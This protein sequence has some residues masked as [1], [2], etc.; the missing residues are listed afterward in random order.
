VLWLIDDN[1]AATKNLR[2]YASRSGA[3][4]SRI[5]FSPRSSYAEYRASLR[6]A[7]VFLDTY[8]YNCG[9]TTN[10]VVQAR[11][12]IVTVGGDT[13]VS[14][15]GTSILQAL[16][17]PQLIAADLNDYEN[18]VV[19]L[20][21]GKINLPQEAFNPQTVLKLTRQMVRSLESGLLQLYE[22]RGYRLTTDHKVCATQSF[23]SV[24]SSL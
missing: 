9:S 23:H 5:I 10:D 4:L 6:L 21:E 19:Q 11:L 22:Q 12:P 7:N 14:R 20:A 13:M 2:D 3:D 8:P 24:V 15:M 16:N 17:L 1:P 18:R